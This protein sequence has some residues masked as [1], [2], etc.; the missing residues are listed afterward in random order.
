MGIINNIVPNS[1][2]TVWV[3]GIF[4]VKREWRWVYGSVGE[5]NGPGIGE[6]D[7]DIKRYRNN[8]VRGNL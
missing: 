3:Y 8:F 5:G 7:A 2:L 6:L 4:I 1:Y